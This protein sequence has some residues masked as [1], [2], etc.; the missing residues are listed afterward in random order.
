MKSA[1]VIVNA[2]SGGGHDDERVQSLVD[3]FA[4][5]GAAAEVHLAHGGTEL[6]ALA[7]EAL[8]RRPDMVVAGG[9]DGTVSGVASVL[10]GSDVPLGVL[11]LGTLNH[12]A[13]DLGMPL[14]IE[15]AVGRIVAGQPMRVDV[16]E[17]NGRVFINNSSLGLY[18]DIVHD[19]ERQRKRLGR[20]K[21]PALAWAS[22]TALRRFSFMSVRLSVDGSQKPRR[23]PFVFIGNNAYV[24][25]GFAIGERTAIDGGHLSLY[26]VHR[27][28]RLRLLQMAL[29]ALF[30]RLDQ[31]RDFEVT[32][33]AEIVVESRR[34]R[35]RVATDG[36]ITMMTPPLRFRIRPASLVVVGADRTRSAAV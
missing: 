19:R 30:G 34:K 24:M 20:G 9:G 21:W 28:G 5:A 11:P 1:Y 23:T 26:V 2:G 33:A 15:A 12:F 18:P 16:G 7:K 10:A 36:E 22:L 35:V 32:P 3:S 29:R 6:T 4:R 31:E 27:A 14:D 25:Q 8:A 17:V 13:K